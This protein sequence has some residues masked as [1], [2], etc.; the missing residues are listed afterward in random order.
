MEYDDGH[1]KECCINCLHSVKN[2]K[3][4]AC[5]DR[6]GLLRLLFGLRQIQNPDK[7]VCNYFK[8]IPNQIPNR[9][10]YCEYFGTHHEMTACYNVGLKRLLL[11]GPDLVPASS[12]CRK[13]VMKR[14]YAEHMR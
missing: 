4:I 2:K 5:G 11:W 14:K 13:F 9:C 3:G 7:A 10:E 6:G 1:V 12:T 8:K